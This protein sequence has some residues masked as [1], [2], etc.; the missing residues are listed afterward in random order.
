MRQ[1]I[2][3]KDEQW[4]RATYNRG[5]E[6]ARSAMTQDRFS[7]M[8]AAGFALSPTEVIAEAL[9][10]AAP[11]A[12]RQASSGSTGSALSAGLT[13]RE[14][15]ILRLLV[16]GLSDREIAAALSISERTAGNHVQH[17][18]QKLNVD[19]RTAAAVFAVRHGL[20]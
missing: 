15:E 18:L 2:G 7:A 11:A 9:A 4:Q 12:P 3:V 13:P 10:T 14:R 19:S 8:W 20:S 6:R 5:L 17:I 16:E 1:Q